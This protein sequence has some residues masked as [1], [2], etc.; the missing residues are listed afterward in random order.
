MTPTIV[1]SDDAS[2]NLDFDLQKMLKDMENTEELMNEIEAKAD[3]LQSKI[4]V[5]LAEVGPLPNP[6][7]MLDNEK[8]EEPKNNNSNK[9]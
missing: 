4:N 7:L 2:D 9:D 6:S 5:L 8:K 3:L 1:N